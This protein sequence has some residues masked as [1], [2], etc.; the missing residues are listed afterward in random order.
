MKSYRIYLLSLVAIMAAVFSSC[1]SDEPD[2]GIPIS[3]PVEVEYKWNG[4][5][6][7]ALTGAKPFHVLAYHYDSMTYKHTFAF[8]SDAYM[9]EAGNLRWIGGEHNWGW[10]KMK[11]V[12][13]YPA[14]ANIEIDENGAVAYTDC[15]LL[16]IENEASYNPSPRRPAPKLKFIENIFKHP[17]LMDYLNE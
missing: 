3:L 11:F 4:K 9:D 6:G 2:S 10:D 14:D 5:I 8:E 12:A 1:N 15:L 16:A 17:E 7:D 13:Y